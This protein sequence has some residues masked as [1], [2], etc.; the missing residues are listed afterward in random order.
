MEQSRR[1]FLKAA[2]GGVAASL[3]ARSA[4]F[5]GEEVP[6]GYHRAMHWRALAGKRVQ[7]T[8]CP[9]QCRVADRERGFCGVRE[10]RG[11]TYYTLVYNKVCSSNVDPIE[12]KPLFHF[13]PGSKAL[14]IATAGCNFA[15]KFCQNWNISQFRPEQ[16][17]HVPVTSAS[18]VALARRWGAR[19]IAYTYSE[20]T[21]SYELMHDSAAAARR[22]GLGAV[23]I[24]NGYISPEALKQLAPHMTAYKVDLKAFTDDFYRKICRGTL[25]PVLDTLVLLKEIGLWSEIVVLIIPT[26]N[27]GTDEIKKM[28]AWIVKELGP[29]VP[30][31]FSRFHPTYLLKN[32][33]PTP[34]STLERC[35][36]I[37][38]DAGINYVYIGNVPG[39]EAESTYCPGCGTT[40]IKRWGFLVVRNSL[41]DGACPRCGRKIPGVWSLPAKA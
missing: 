39:H 8:L 1:R 38:R 2:A 21:I 12:K 19:S 34:V 33:P 41:K 14:S 9:R 6:D 4:L 16:V 25:K 36:R 11:G 23:A 10:N 29:D 35:R 37:A 26:L 15:C 18:L 20:P 17:H 22:A 13:L 28:C 31:H 5:A 3:S 32:L 27:D 7:C 30:V 24:S 40:L